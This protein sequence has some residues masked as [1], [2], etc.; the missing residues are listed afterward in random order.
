MG[1]NKVQY[2]NTVLID[3]TDTTAV[4]SD[5]LAGKY[6]YGKDGVKTLGT[7]TD[8]GIVQGTFTTGSSAGVSS[9]SIPYTGSGYPISCNVFV[10]GGS[11]NSAISGW[12]NSV[13]RYAVGMWAMTKA[14]TT[15]TPSYGET[16]SEN[17]GVVLSL[18]KNS[19]SNPSSYSRTSS[20]GLV[21]YS[22]TD[23]GN[24][25]TNCIRLKSSKLLSY[26]VSTSS[27]G[28]LPNTKYRYIITYSS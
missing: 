9:V 13:Q 15:S 27:Y 25:A 7:G 12:Y 3:L 23:A 6:F 14:V 19:T 18:Y 16:G 8:G 24:T 10:D 22:T 17:H 1:I 20:V 5:V 11:Y 28:L 4:A 2:G 26:Y 21:C